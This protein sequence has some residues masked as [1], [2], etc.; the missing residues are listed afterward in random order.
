MLI[1]K[2]GVQRTPEGK[3][4]LGQLPTTTRAMDAANNANIRQV[5]PT[6]LQMPVRTADSGES[7]SKPTPLAAIHPKES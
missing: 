5:V 4:V 2:S 1:D 3:I 7:F 6:K